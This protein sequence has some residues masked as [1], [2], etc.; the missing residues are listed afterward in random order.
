MQRERIGSKKVCKHCGKEFIKTSPNEK[1]CKD[2][3]E[4]VRKEQVRERM[5]KYYYRKNYGEEV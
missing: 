5:K 3:K 2:C 4:V 1:Y